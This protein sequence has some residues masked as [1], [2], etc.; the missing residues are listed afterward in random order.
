MALMTFA[1]VMTML[2]LWVSTA[3]SMITLLAALNFA[4]LDAVFFEYCPICSVNLK[5]MW[6]EYACNPEKAN[7]SK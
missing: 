7:F 1:A 3:I 4:S 6:C 5:M 2:K